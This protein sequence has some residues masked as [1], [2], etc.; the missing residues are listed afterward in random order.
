M[1]FGPRPYR[2][3]RPFDYYPTP[4]PLTEA[5]L[6]RWTPPAGCTIAEP[7]AGDGAITRVLERHGYDV[8]TGDLDPNWDWVDFQGQDFL[9]PSSLEVYAGVDIIITNVPFSIAPDII[10]QALRITPYVLSILPLN[11]LSPTDNRRGIVELPGHAIVFRRCKWTDFSGDG[12]D[13]KSPMW[14]I[15]SPEFEDLTVEMVWK[16]ELEELGGQNLLL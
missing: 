2:G 7:C 14:R 6:R 16:E 8:V 13:S 5:L 9:H 11:W 3:R 4:E 12:G 1:S 10:T 15:W